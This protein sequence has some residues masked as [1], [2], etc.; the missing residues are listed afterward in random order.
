MAYF[1]DGHDIAAE[2][3]AALEAYVSSTEGAAATAQAAREFQAGEEAVV[4]FETSNPE[5]AVRLDL[6]N[7]TV[8]RGGGA[9]TVGLRMDAD[10]MHDLMLDRLDGGQ[11]ARAFEEGR[12]AITGP[13]WALDALVKI[14]QSVS[15]CW[16]QSLEAR[17]RQDLLSA[18]P[19]PPAG[20]W[21]K[22]YDPEVFV[23]Q[24]IPERKRRIQE[25]TRAG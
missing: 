16:R 6:R 9:A 5:A 20:V 10:T 15:Q 18:P 1:R 11:I 24:I 12:L 22:Y 25:Y 21:E 8:A 4:L 23:E 19:P 17:G 14:S 7:R 2:L 3:V 13:P